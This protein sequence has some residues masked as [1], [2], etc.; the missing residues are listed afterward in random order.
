MA[1]HVH[2][3]LANLEAGHEHGLEAHE[4]GRDAGP[5][6]VRVQPLQLR[7]DDANVL[8]ARRRREAGKPLHRLAKSEGVNVGADAAD[9]LHQRD[10]LNVVAG[11]GQMLDAAEVE[12]DM[13]LGVDYGLAFADHVQLVGFFQRRMIGTHG[14]LVA[15]FFSSRRFTPS[16][17]PWRSSRGSYS[18]PTKSMPNPS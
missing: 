17:S 12:A 5:E 15:H 10:D 4:L 8:R 3:L 6:D 16:V 9:P 18:R 13:Q 7:H 14:N 1:E 11:F 2:H